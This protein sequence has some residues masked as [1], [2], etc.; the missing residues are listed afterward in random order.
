MWTPSRYTLGFSWIVRRVNSVLQTVGAES[1][2]AA[3]GAVVIDILDIFGFENFET[4]SFEQLCIN[5]ANEKLHQLFLHTMFKAEE[6]VVARERVTLPPVEYCDNH[7]C[8]AM[9]EN[10]PSGIFHQLDTCCRVHASPAS[11]CLQV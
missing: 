3:G 5:F 1:S 2:A 8:L 7:R 4:N 11:F 9:L 10:H 6:E